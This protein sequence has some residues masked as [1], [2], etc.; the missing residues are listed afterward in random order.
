MI[1]F[2]VGP[3]KLKQLFSVFQK[4][5]GV[6]RIVA[7]VF[8]NNSRGRHRGRHLCHQLAAGFVLVQLVRATLHARPFRLVPVLLFQRRNTDLVC[9]TTVKYFF[10]VLLFN[11]V[12]QECNFKRALVCG[13]R[14]FTWLVIFKRL[15]IWI[16]YNFCL[17][18]IYA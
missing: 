5:V 14:Q 16:K 13:S 6:L 8:E 10:Y 2:P 4:N 17:G 12:K 3:C 15:R 18:I 1:L 9:I 7:M 11:K